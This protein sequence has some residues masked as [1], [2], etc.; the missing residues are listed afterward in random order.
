MSEDHLKKLV[1]EYCKRYLV[2]ERKLVRYMRNK[3]YRSCRDPEARKILFEQ[4]LLIAA[5]MVEAGLVNDKEAALAKLRSKLRTGYAPKKA[6]KLAEK[7]AEV[8]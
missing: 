8:L 3:I 4:G 1:L 2:S 5:E 6:A 7:L